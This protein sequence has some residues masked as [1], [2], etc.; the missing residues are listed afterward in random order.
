MSTSVASSA[1][2]QAPAPVPADAEVLVGRAERIHPAYAA[3]RQIADAAGWPESFRDDLVKH[4]RGMLASPDAPREFIWHLRPTGT[5][6][7]SLA[8]PNDWY[9]ATLIAAWA[10][11]NHGRDH[12]WFHATQQGRLEEITVADV[13]RVYDR[14][15]SSDSI[16][17]IDVAKDDVITIN[18]RT[19]LV[20]SAS[21]SFRDVSLRG[22]FM[23]DVGHREDGG[24]QN[25]GFLAHDARLTIRRPQVPR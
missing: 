22:R 8:R 7:C 23:Q 18:G 16:R 21:R 2:S 13:A 24:G 3:M 19:A 17:A 20:E 12:R 15:W 4:D 5:N 10:D 25:L 6:L 9:Y 11:Y 14:T 1:P